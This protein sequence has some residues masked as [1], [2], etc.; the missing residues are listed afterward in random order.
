MYWRWNYIEHAFSCKDS[1]VTWKLPQNSFK[2]KKKGC[3]VAYLSRWRVKSQKNK[4]KCECGSITN[5]ME[6][7]DRLLKIILFES[8]NQ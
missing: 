1:G 2:K 4:A 8:H 7:V 3:S 6:I 5:A